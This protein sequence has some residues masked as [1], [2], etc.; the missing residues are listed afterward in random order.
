MNAT[1]PALSIVFMVISLIGS[2]AIPVALAVFLRKKYKCDILPFFI[3]C[4]VMLVFAFI[5]E[6]I[7]HGVVLTVFPGLRSRS[8][9]FA[10]Y[11][12]LM[13]GLFEETGRFAAFKTVLKKAQ[14]NDHNA[15]MY[16]AGHGGFEAAAILGIAMINNLFFAFLMNSGN[17]SLLLNS[18]TFSAVPGGTEQMA[19]IENAMTQ[20]AASPSYL[21]L[22][23]LVERM[24]AIV[25]HIS[26]S[27]LVWNAVKYHRTGYVLLAIALHTAVDA[28]TVILSSAGMHPALLEVVIILMSAGCAILSRSL[29]QG[30]DIQAKGRSFG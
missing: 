13:A 21:F 7:A 27:V 4:A 8:V 5:L 29:I 14:H 28:V 1:V 17:A 19:A 3:G 18:G 20:L 15:L 22:V 30:Y 6:Q 2:V 10:L 16:G 9:L 25:L 11:A 24:A 12:G 26:F 23:G